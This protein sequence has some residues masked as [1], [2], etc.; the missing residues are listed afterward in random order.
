MYLQ[1]VV[2]FNNRLLPLALMSYI[3]IWPSMFTASCG[4]S[5][6]EVFLTP[7]ASLKISVHGMLV[8]LIRGCV[9]AVLLRLC[10]VLTDGFELFSF[11]YIMKTL[12]IDIQ[13]NDF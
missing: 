7:K 2:I 8:L 5:I 1:L 6:F 13:L 9:I 3:S 4:V 10:Q 12:I 11:L